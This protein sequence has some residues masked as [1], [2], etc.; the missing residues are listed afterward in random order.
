MSEKPI[1]NEL[2]KYLNDELTKEFERALSAAPWWCLI[3]GDS[4]N[5]NGQRPAKYW[6]PP[7][8]HVCKSIKPKLKGIINGC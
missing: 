8:D 6:A 1:C 7:K 2:K 3:C 5:Y 4:G